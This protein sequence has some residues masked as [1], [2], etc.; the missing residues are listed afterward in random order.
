MSGKTL[1]VVSLNLRW[2]HIFSTFI[3]ED[4]KFMIMIQE[5]SSVGNGEFACDVLGRFLWQE[6]YVD[7]IQL[8][9]STWQDMAVDWCCFQELCPVCNLCTE[10][11][12]DP[13]L[14]LERKVD[15]LFVWCVWVGPCQCLVSSES[16]FSAF[17]GLENCSGNTC[18]QKC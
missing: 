10:W 18:F 17:T 6:S 16:F 7:K 15:D 4:Q 2:R 12:P 11:C 3:A 14:L 1:L 5:W 9:S 8:V 13:F